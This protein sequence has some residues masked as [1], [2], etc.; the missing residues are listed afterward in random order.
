LLPVENAWASRANTLDGAYGEISSNSA[1]QEFATTLLEV[2]FHDNAQDA[3]NM[4]DP[5]SATG[6]RGPS[7]NRR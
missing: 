4:R 2:A 3:Q 6:S 7:I 1:G 5:R